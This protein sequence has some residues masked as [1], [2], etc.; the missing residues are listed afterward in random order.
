MNPVG[1]VTRL[2]RFSPGET[3]TRLLGS[4]A[5]RGLTVL[6]Q[7]DHAAAAAKIGLALR[8]TAVIIFGN[9]AAG[10]PLMQSAQS[11]GIDLPLKAM[12]WEDEGGKVWVS[13]DDLD[14]LADRHG[15]APE[16][17]TTIGAMARGVKAVVHQATGTAA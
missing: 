15:L 16:A 13:H 3:Q 12:I 14:W 17:R 10:T 4:I 8:P 9:P 5:S 6:A 2:S 11:F 1:L 7:I